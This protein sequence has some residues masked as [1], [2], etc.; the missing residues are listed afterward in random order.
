GLE[1]LPIRPSIQIAVDRA[2]AV[3]LVAVTV[4][5]VPLVGEAAVVAG[6][7][8]PVLDPFAIA[9]VVRLALDVARVGALPGP[10]VPVKLRRASR[11]R[12]PDA[13][14]EKQCLTRSM[15]SHVRPHGPG[16]AGTARKFKRDAIRRAR[17]SWEN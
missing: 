17:F 14:D 1:A 10:A 12:D 2:A 13:R 4:F 7:V 8:L 16:K 11:R 3:A 6:V 15:D 5:V 9:D